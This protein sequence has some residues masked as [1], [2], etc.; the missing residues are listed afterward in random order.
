MELLKAL[1]A[2]LRVFL[3]SRSA[4]ALENLA[5]RHQR[6]VLERTAKRPRLRKRDRLF[7]TWLARL[8]PGWKSVLVIVQ[9]ETVLDADLR[10]AE[11]GSIAASTGLTIT[12]LTQLDLFYAIISHRRSGPTF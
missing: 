3:A 2:V 10:Q 11:R 9:P 1:V 4:L 7:W 6:M 8:W 12:T 5:L